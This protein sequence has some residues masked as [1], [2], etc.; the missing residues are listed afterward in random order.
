M[1]SETKKDDRYHLFV[2]ARPSFVGP[3]WRPPADVYR[4]P[5][6][7]VVKLDVAGLRPED[8][9]VEVQ[10]GRLVVSGSRRDML[11][12]LGY[13]HHSMEITYSRFERQVALPGN[14]DD[15]ELSLATRDG[16]LLIDIRTREDR[17][18]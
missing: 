12:H 3:P 9:R 18:G 16:W 14:L 17:H 7:W 13:R 1:A 11:V 5:H 8:V 6:G 4:S 15:A 2:Q 10:D